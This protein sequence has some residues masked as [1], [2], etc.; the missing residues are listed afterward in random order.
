MT[1]VIILGDLHAGARNSN[2]TVE[3]WQ[4]K[5]FSELL[6]PYVKDNGIKRIIQLGDLYDNR[7]WLNMNTISWF[8]DVFVKPS[9]ELGVTIDAII[10]NHDTYYKHTNTPNSPQLLLT[11]FDNFNIFDTIGN[12]EIDDVNFTMIPWMCKENYDET[13]EAVKQGGDICVGHFDI[14]GFVMHPGAISKD[15]LRLSDF[16]N[17][18]TVWSGHYHTQS[19]NQNVQYLGTPYQMNWSDANS[20]HG[21]WV[22][23]TTDR[24]MEFVENPYRYFHRFYWNEGCDA[25]VTKVKDGYVKVNVEKKTDFESF[26]NF[27]DRINFNDPFELKVLESHEEFSQ[28]N[29]QDL[30]NLSSTEEL[31]EEYIEEVATNTNKDNVKALMLNIYQEA[32]TIEDL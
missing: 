18:N 17:W 25:D 13:Y 4:E 19:Q 11:K 22:F 8:E 10:G 28:E 29:V 24:S 27:I 16:E 7:R 15:G 26:E 1:K 3:L 23:D 30:I 20:K 6:W 31:I 9:Q 2:K 12:L 14:Q 32:M 21:F 5:F